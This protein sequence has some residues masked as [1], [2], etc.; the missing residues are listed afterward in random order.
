[1]PYEVFAKECIVAE[2]S[3]EAGYVNDPDDLGKET[4]HGITIGL[5]KKNNTALYTKFRWSGKMIDLTEEMAYWLYKYE[6]WDKLYLDDVCS[7]SKSL[8]RTMFRWGLKSGDSRPVTALQETLNCLNNKA[9]YWPELVVDG[10]FGKRTLDAI[11]AL[12]KKRGRD[13]AMTFLV[14]QTNAD[15]M[16]FFKHITLVR[17]DEKNERFYWGW[18]LRSIREVDGYIGKYGIPK[19]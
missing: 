19:V 14:A 9:A 5:A 16:A 11:D 18:G 12:I 3:I 4:N 7:R 1:M 6:F 13:A 10:W 2:T 15:Q 17:P 8:A